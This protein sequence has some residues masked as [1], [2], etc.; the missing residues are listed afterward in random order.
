MPRLLHIML[1]P[2]D[3]M[4]PQTTVASVCVSKRVFHVIFVWALFAVCVCLREFVCL[5]CAH[6]LQRQSMA[7]I[8][9]CTCLVRRA[10]AS[11]VAL[12][13]ISRLVHTPETPN[14]QWM[15]IEYS[16]MQWMSIEKA[17]LICVDSVAP[18]VHGT[19]KVCKL[20]RGH[21]Y[22]WCM[23]IVCKLHWCSVSRWIVFVCYM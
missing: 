22:H 4:L 20:Q 11:S 10:M 13:R 8:T 5:Q 7:K 18:H 9:Q 12:L 16:F 6:Y 2:T 21:G 3:Y 14:L 19:W 15:S 1:A 23:L 17:Q